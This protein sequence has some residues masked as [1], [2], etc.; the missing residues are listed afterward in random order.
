MLFFSGR[1]LAGFPPHYKSN[2]PNFF[3]IIEVRVSTNNPKP[4][5]EEKD[6]LLKVRVKAKPIEGKANAEVIELLAKH[7][8]V[9]ENQVTI[10]A[11]QTSK[12][13]TIEIMR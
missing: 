12:K 5:A 11:G 13:K 10:V 6:G 4:G 9:K 3:M 2:L 1:C 8:G 7:Y